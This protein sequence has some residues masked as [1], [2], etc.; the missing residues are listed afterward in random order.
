MHQDLEFSKEANPDIS[1]QDSTELLEDFI[2]ELSAEFQRIYDMDVHRSCI[3]DLD[4][5]TEQEIFSS[6]CHTLAQQCTF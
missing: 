6:P 1:E 2:A 3:V 5:S 4:S